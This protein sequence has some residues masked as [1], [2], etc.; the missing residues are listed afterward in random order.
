MANN[1]VKLT[2]FTNGKAI[3]ET[4]GHAG[5]IGAH[6][7]LRYDG[8]SVTLNERIDKGLHVTLE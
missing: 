5:L 7:A 3:Y 1:S 6:T 8:Y 4:I 2:Y